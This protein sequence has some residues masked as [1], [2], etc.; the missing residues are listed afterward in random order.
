MGAAA[1]A[2]AAAAV[3]QLGAQHCG[4]AARGD[5]AVTSC[6][7][8][9]QQR[10]RP[11]RWRPAPL[12][13]SFVSRS[14]AGEG[15]A[16]TWAPELAAERAA[17]GAP[18]ESEAAAAAADRPLEGQWARA[19]SIHLIVGP[20]FAGKTTRLLACVRQQSSAG[21]RIEL[22]KSAKDKRYGEYTV[23]S[24]DGQ[25]MP[26]TPLSRL[27]DLRSRIGPQRY[28]KAEVIG[29]DEAQFFGDLADF[30]L[31]AADEDGKIIFVAGLDGDFRRAKFGSVVD[32]LPLAD[33]VEKLLS[34]CALCGQEGVAPFTVRKTADT[35]V[36]LVG[37]ADIYMPCCRR[38]RKGFLDC[39]QSVLH[40]HV[41]ELG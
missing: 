20:M 34:R 16:P 23:S 22:V 29:I 1:T 41:A 19:G 14:H 6:R 27:E 37:G 36:E 28:S 21:R 31:R 24:H 13:G 35:E 38:C 11:G 26:C 5:G 39:Q 25:H 33:S 3:R 9:S 4:A 8:A 12:L 40:V 2:A 7:L 30:C 32:L 10:G 15:A 17:A 18:G